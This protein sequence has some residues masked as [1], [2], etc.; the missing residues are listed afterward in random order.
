MKTLISLIL[1]R[2]CANIF[3]QTVIPHYITNGNWYGPS[4]QFCMVS[5]NSKSNAK[6]SNYLFEKIRFEE[7]TAL[8]GL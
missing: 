3:T 5:P 4:S 6:H 8:F 2:F 1:S 7:L